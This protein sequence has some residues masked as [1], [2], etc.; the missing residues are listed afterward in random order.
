M[1]G[2][3]EPQNIE[4]IW[5]T[6]RG[7]EALSRI[8]INFSK[9]ELYPMNIS[10]ENAVELAQIFG[11][12]VGHFPFKYLG[13]P[14]SYQKLRVRDWEF[15]IR[16]VESKLQS[17]KSRLLSLG[18]RL[19]LL[20]SAISSVPLYS[21]ST[22]H[23]PSTILSRLNR[24]RRKILWQCYGLNQRKYSL[25]NWPQVCLPKNQGGMGVLDLELMNL[26]LLAK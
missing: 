17:W 14:L 1:F 5:W 20:N 9:T 16:K 15:L 25:I 10:E 26:S 18:G 13:L 6:V 7:F 21:L 24:A 19:T 23:V 2:Q 3:A 11:C 8:K 4:K 12:Q 22:F